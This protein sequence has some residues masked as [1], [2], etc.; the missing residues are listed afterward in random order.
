[1]LGG[2]G[3]WGTSGLPVR[4]RRRLKNYDTK[5]AI[6]CW[7]SVD[8]WQCGIGLLR[9]VELQCCCSCRCGETV[10][11]NCGLW[12]AYCS[13]P[14]LC[15]RQESH[16]GVILTGENRKSRKK[17]CPSATFSTSDPTWID[18]GLRSDRPATNRLSHDTACC[19]SLLMICLVYI[20]VCRRVS[21]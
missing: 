1:M 5:D 14:R 8:L 13:S 20:S 6:P 4:K 9:I 11:L 19:L 17:T 16:G 15:V 2:G 12:R 7:F 10:S 3:D 18:S 21:V